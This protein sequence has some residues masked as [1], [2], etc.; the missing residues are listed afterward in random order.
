MKT[1]S[2]KTEGSVMKRTWKR[3][4]FALIYTLVFLNAFSLHAE[5]VKENVWYPNLFSKGDLLKG[6][7]RP[8]ELYDRY[9]KPLNCDKYLVFN[10]E[11]AGGHFD[12]GCTGTKCCKENG[13]CYTESHFEDS[14]TY[15]MAYFGTC[16][17]NPDILINNEKNACP[18]ASGGFRCI[19][20]LTTYPGMN[21]GVEKKNPEDPCDDPKINP[22]K[23]EQG[24][25]IN[26]TNGNNIQSEV[27]L[28]F[29]TPFDGGLYFGRYYNSQGRH[30]SPLGNGWTHNYNLIL[31]TDAF[32]NPDLIKITG[33]TGRAWYFEYDNQDAVY[34]GAFNGITVVSVNE[35]GEFVWTRTNG[36]SYIFNGT[37]HKLTAITDKNDNIQAL[38]YTDDDEML[39]TVTDQASG[40]FLSFHY[41]PD[42]TLE[43][44][45]GPESETVPAQSP[46]VTYTVENGNLMKVEYADNDNGSSVSGFRYEYDDPSDD[47][48]SGDPN[49]YNDPMTAKYDLAGHFISSWKYD[50]SR[51]AYKNID[52]DGKGV[53]IDYS[54][55]PD[56][57][58]VTDV[59]GITTTYSIERVNG[60]NKINN[61]TRT[62]QENCD[63]CSEGVKRVEFDADGNPNEKE[64]FN[65]KVVEYQDYDDYRNPGTIIVKSGED[66]VKTI[67][68]DYHDRLST[69][70]KITENSTFNDAGNPGRE[71][72]V[73]Y[74][75]DDPDNDALPL[76]PN[77]QKT[78]RVYRIIVQGFTHDEN[79]D[80]VQFEYTTK[81]KYDAKG[82]VTHIDG[83][84]P[85]T[86]DT[87]EYKHDPVTGDLLEIISPLIGDRGRSFRVIGDVRSERTER[88]ASMCEW[89]GIGIKRFVSPMLCH[90][91]SAVKG[92]AG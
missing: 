75:Y 64:Y 88:G 42:K 90:H 28:F 45:S 72:I 16:N 13:E 69:P 6:K 33:A 77:S 57:V 71:K 17:E 31:E 36:K 8:P 24:D 74:D 47:G 65:G 61:Q 58:D 49:P 60:I 51:R 89:F 32:L 48:G 62:G 27:D 4:L 79:G 15:Q 30:V 86:V 63:S 92:V 41:R 78:N 82:Q 14:S 66:V 68:I 12:A 53:T 1:Y 70:L 10:G 91:V 22:I 38:S 2:L 56:S 5:D 3:F 83:P 59:Y 73:I 37:T 55:L 7:C 52:R 18:V 29:N 80:V 35:S 19:N 23:K 25:P 46:W 76:T 50:T 85:G 34:K 81:M 40:R 39:E 44:I 21:D 43:Y 9:I 20:D 11:P 26:I 67:R 84:L 54:G 87:T